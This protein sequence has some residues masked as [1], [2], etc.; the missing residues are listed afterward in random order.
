M[1]QKAESQIGIEKKNGLSNGKLFSYIEKHTNE[2][3]SHAACQH[4]F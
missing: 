2:I 1:L 3:M 4:K